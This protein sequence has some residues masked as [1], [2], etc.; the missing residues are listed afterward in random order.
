MCAYGI[1]DFGQIVG[2]GSINGGA[3]RAFLLT[4]PELIAVTVGINPNHLNLQSKGNWI[5]CII[6]FPQDVNI[7]MLIPTHFCLTAKL[8]QNGLR[9]MKRPEYDGKFSR[10]EVEASCNQ[11][12]LN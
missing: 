9:L 8:R 5:T 6:S 10:S 3:G 2:E 7:A 4:R 11:E 12:Q 1:N